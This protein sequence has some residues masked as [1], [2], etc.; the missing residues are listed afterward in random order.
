MP[1]T[2][3]EKA[4]ELD[5]LDALLQGVDD[6]NLTDFQDCLNIIQA[7]EKGAHFSSTH[8][9]VFAPI[10]KHIHNTRTASRSNKKILASWFKSPV[11]ANSE[12]SATELSGI[13]IDNT[14]IAIRDDSFGDAIKRIYED[15]VPCQDRLDLLVSFRP[16]VDFLRTFEEDVRRKIEFLTNLD[17]LL[18]NVDS[19]GDICQLLKFLNFMCVP[20]L[21]RMISIL[22]ASLA[23]PNVKLDSLFSVLS[24]LIIPFFSP[25]LTGIT[26]MLLQYEQLVLAPIECAI[27]A[28][29]TNLENL[30]VGNVFD[31]ALDTLQS[32]EN[33]AREE[34]T[35]GTLGLPEG[36]MRTG[37]ALIHEKLVNADSIMRGKVDFYMCQLQALLGDWNGNGDA[38]LVASFEK[39]QTIQLLD[40]I[41][42]I[43][44]LK[45][46]GGSVC[47]SQGPSAG[48]ELDNFFNNFLN[49]NSAFRFVVD[50]NGNVK[51][52]EPL[53]P[54]YQVEKEELGAKI[55]SY[56]P[57]DLLTK[58]VS[59]TV[60]CT[61]KTDPSD[62][63]KIN[64]LIKELD[65]VE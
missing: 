4:I 43:I 48:R 62:V 39:M 47:A 52:E 56:E 15:C 37:L 2:V 49:P 38:I 44:D 25:I 53:P 50:N 32:A 20:D 46:K 57:D 64:K 63:E 18:S 22:M 10:S 36:S 40:L 29:E 8:S 14:F 45:R 33:A 27:D 51:V 31:P 16:N 41:A 26:N 6:V 11:V 12:S 59:T 54:L 35:Q 24:G 30:N 23:I 65:K 55:I 7:Y 1:A 9:S 3:I 61:F 42:A 21:Q 58:P 60:G 13:E 28:L 17:N 5:D 34:I 19:Y